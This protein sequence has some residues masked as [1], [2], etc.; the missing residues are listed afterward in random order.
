MTSCHIAAGIIEETAT[1]SA[2]VDM[3]DME[4][5]VEGMRNLFSQQEEVLALQ[6]S[7]GSGLRSGMS[8]TVNYDKP[9][10]SIPSPLLLLL[11]HL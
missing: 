3:V 5:A 6:K 8:Y 10:T 1:S 4:Y 7:N 11:L 2:S 9:S